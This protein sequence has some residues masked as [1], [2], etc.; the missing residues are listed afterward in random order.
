MTLPHQEVADTSQACPAQMESP[1]TS[2]HTGYSLQSIAS[3]MAVL[4]ILGAGSIC[5]RAPDGVCAEPLASALM[6]ALVSFA[7]NYA[8]LFT[9]SADFADRSGSKTYGHEDAFS[10]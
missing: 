8:G 2:M 10:K 1:C 4:T 9:S 3:L 7:Q 6:F 5:L